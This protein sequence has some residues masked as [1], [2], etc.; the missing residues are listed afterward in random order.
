[1]EL[2]QLRYF[3]SVA[4][5]ES[6]N[7]AS[8]QLNVAQSALS[9]QIRLL[10]EELGHR[11]LHRTGRGATL[12]PVGELLLRRASALLADADD[13]KTSVSAAVDIAGNVRLG[14]PAA[15]DGTLTTRIIERC[16]AEHPGVCIHFC[17][18]LT[19][20]L[21]EW[22][23]DRRIDLAILYSR[24]TVHR[25]VRCADL[26]TQPMRLV[27]APGMSPT[28]GQPISLRKVAELPLVLLERP[29]GSRLTIDDAFLQAGITPSSVIEVSAWLV[30][31]EFLLTGKGYGLLP[32]PE[33]QTEIEAGR[34]AA[35]PIDE[36]EIVRTLCI[37]RTESKAASRA[38]D[39]VFRLMQHHT[40]LWTDYGEAGGGFARGEERPR[41]ASTTRG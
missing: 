22:L 32:A 39:E 29:N 21:L 23:L 25:P 27:H 36:P 33:V 26:V 24:Q 40:G 7:R 15:F 8:A 41:Y 2:R 38:T 10:E 11:L 3:V 20:V 1:M 19:S 5:F 18:G 12:T 6:F 9:R 17:E 34:L 28:G 4:R 31:R 35:T 16:Q 30:L 37:A 14:I 13:L